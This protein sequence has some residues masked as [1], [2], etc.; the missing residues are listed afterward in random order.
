MEGNSSRG[1]T[2]VLT[3]G[4][5][6]A[7]ITLVLGVWWFGNAFFPRKVPL[8]G[9]AGRE[10]MEAHHVAPQYDRLVVMVVDAMRADFLYDVALGRA[11]EDLRNRTAA[12]ERGE[13]S[14]A[15]MRWVREEL[16]AKGRAVPLIGRAQAPTVTLPRVKALVSGSIPS[17][18]DFVANF[19]SPSLQ[20]D[21]IVRQLRAA[22]KRYEFSRS[23]NRSV[24]L[25]NRADST[26]TE[27]TLGS[28]CSHPRRMSSP[29]TKER[30]PF[31]CQTTL[32]WTKC[33]KMPRRRAVSALAE[34]RGRQRGG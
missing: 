26:S 2:R 22:G 17:F 13:R 23:G 24:F 10:A 30:L 19:D 8:Q 28:S 33:D 7:V 18:L 6:V 5:A 29:A 4:C 1:E 25:T 27:M 3:I 11:E 34:G 32:K 14:G 21:S 31:S 20:E 12:T 9:T 15:E 16:I